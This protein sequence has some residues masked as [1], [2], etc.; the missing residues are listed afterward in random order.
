MESLYNDNDI[1]CCKLYPKFHTNCHSLQLLPGP[2][3][4]FYLFAYRAWIHMNAMRGARRLAAQLGVDGEQTQPHDSKFVFTRV[5]VQTSGEEAS[6]GPNTV[7]EDQY[8]GPDRDIQEQVRAMLKATGVDFSQ[9]L[10]AA[11]RFKGKYR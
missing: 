6:S 7:T 11:V 4:P 9:H 10:E 8:V 1:I 5:N 2:N 3:V